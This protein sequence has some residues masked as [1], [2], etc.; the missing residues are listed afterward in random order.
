M[1][2]LLEDHSYLEDTFYSNHP[3]APLIPALSSPSTTSSQQQHI[4][5]DIPDLCYLYNTSRPP[6]YLRD[7]KMYHVDV[8]G[9]R[10]SQSSTS[11]TLYPLQWYVSYSGLSYT[12]RSFVINI[13][14]LIEPTMYQHACHYEL[15][16]LGPKGQWNMV[17]S[18]TTSWP[19]TYLLQM[20]I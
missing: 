16:D 15:W 1:T 17:H 2:P 11:S 3:F 5:Q 12:Y 20:S 18:S 13:S 14:L 6:P 9:H 10:D 4:Q 8:L 7:F 19:T